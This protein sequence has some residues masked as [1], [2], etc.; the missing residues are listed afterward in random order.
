MLVCL[1]WYGTFAEQI[2]RSMNVILAMLFF[3]VKLLDN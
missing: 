1:G 3:N 2:M